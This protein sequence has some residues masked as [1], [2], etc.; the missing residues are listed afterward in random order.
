MFLHLKTYFTHRQS[1]AVGLV[2]A[3][4]GFLF[5]N[6]VT[7]IPYIKT[8]FELN[9]AQLGFLL[10]SMP[11]GATFFNPVVTLLLR[12]FGMLAVTFWGM[13]CMAIAYALPVNMGYLW[14][15]S[16]SLALV[17]ISIS[18]T[19]IAMNTCVMAIEKH[20]RVAI[21]S[22]CHGMFSLGGMLG[23]FL[24]SFLTGAQVAASW[25]MIGMGLLVILLALIIKKYIYQ[26]YEEPTDDQSGAAFVWPKGVLLGMIAISLCTNITEGA[27]ADWTAVYM[28]EIV[29]AN[30]FF[31]GWGFASYALFMAL[32]RF[33]GDT[34]IPRFGRSKVLIVGGLLATFGVLVVV[35]FPNTI[36]AIVGFAF[37]GAGVSCGAPILYS[38]S[39]EIPNMAKGAGL[40]TLNTF[41]IA[42]FLAGPAIIGFIS[43]ASSLSWGI[44]IVGILGLLWSFLA[45]RVPL[46]HSK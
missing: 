20:E 33:V 11:F 28:R 46:N 14:G 35:V 5:G 38:S 3:S 2:F 13:A 27:M 16:V 34:I 1:I 6:W 23:S 40:A 44:G 4:M 25:Q 43:N 8:K 19:N 21:M 29:A 45:N 9:D 30:P 24:A 39:L 26:I 42:G 10:L 37:V 41:S 22:T 12:R 36:S 18:T 31:I 15:A 7:H 32:G 17:G